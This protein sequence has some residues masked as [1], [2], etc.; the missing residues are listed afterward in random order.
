M[1]QQTRVETVERYWSAFIDR[2]P[3]VDELAAADEESVL[4][5]W[6]GLGYYRR[7]RLL[8][9]GARYVA[10]EL[11]G[12]IPGD[13]D[14]LRKIPGVGRYTAG[15]ISSIAFDR[16]AA[17]VDG[18]VARVFSRLRGVAEPKAQDA[19]AKEHWALA[20]AVVE[21][22]TP[23][24]VAQA[25]MELGA[26]VCTPKSPRCLLCPLRSSCVA[27]REGI[28][29]SI[30]APKKRVEQPVTRYW[31]LAVVSRKRLL[32]VRRPS[33]G[34]LAK[35]WCLPLIEARA[36]SPSAAALCEVL[37]VPVEPR[38][39]LEPVR[40]VFTH[41]IWEMTPVPV[42]LC[43]R[44]VARGYEDQAWIAAGQRPAGG[45]PSATEK[46]LRAVGF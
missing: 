31:A 30:P 26:V 7:A 22:G 13:A 43:R 15:A 34:I 29:D 2:F 42:R 44:A 32:V 33:E 37:D 12:R 28:V 4:Q 46:L 23:R 38:A 5:A 3:S 24:V 27:Q 10:E 17:L 25:L 18:N 21:Q 20:K 45:V 11:G 6:S 19:N 16:P 9:R 36:G 40:H 35:M 41:R 1:L 8:H 39:T 14:A